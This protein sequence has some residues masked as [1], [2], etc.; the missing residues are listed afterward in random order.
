MTAELLSLIL[1]FVILVALVGTIYYAFNLSRSLN[2]F[3]RQREEMKAMIN[4]LVK[5][6]DDAQTA[7]D[8][9]KAASHIAAD[10][11]DDV[12]HESQKMAEELKIIN[13][14]SN[15]LANR[16]EKTASNARSVPTASYDEDRFDDDDDEEPSGG[17]DVIEPPSFFIQDRDFEDDEDLDED[18]DLSRAERELIEALQGQKQGRGG[19]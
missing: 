4:E 6:I 18:A 17:S 14:T 12:L 19:R 11:L 1:D 9:L 3:K 2:N 15:S 8:G 16:L 13:E 7:I 5:N 10:N